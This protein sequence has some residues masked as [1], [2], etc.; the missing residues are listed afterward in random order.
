VTISEV[1]DPSLANRVID[2]GSTSAC[3][4]MAQG[5]LGCYDVSK[6][7]ITLIRGWNWY[8]G[9][10]PSRIG[11][12]QYDFQTTVE[13]EL[14][15][16]LGLGGVTDSNSPMDE[17]LAAGVAKRTVTAQ[18]LNILDPPEGADLENAAGSS[19]VRPP[20]F[21]SAV[22]SGFATAFGPDTAFTSA[23]GTRLTTSP[24][25]I[26]VSP[27]QP[28]VGAL[29][30]S[31][32][33][34]VLQGRDDNDEHSLSLARARTDVRRDSWLDELASALVQPR[35]QEPARAS[36]RP[37]HP[38]I[39]V[40]AAWAGPDANRPDGRGHTA[41]PTGPM[42]RPGSPRPAASWADLVLVAGFCGFGAGLQATTKRRSG[43]PA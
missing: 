19:L 34:M 30:D 36:H 20:A 1:S 10:D 7:E 17:R 35:G 22:S 42:A 21:R 8:T 15:H 38:W 27:A 5:V 12:G 43:F 6:G 25:Q 26:A 18:D 4:G 9:A 41:I 16:A 23:Q 29:A 11:P 40:G 3:G 39:G 33:A 24:R 28:V 31:G 37:V 32:H 2:A 14:G 13:H